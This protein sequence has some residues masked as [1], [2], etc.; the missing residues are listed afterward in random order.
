MGEATLQKSVDTK[1]HLSFYGGHYGTN[2]YLI[3]VSNFTEH[4]IMWDVFNQNTIDWVSLL[5]TLIYEVLGE[6]QVLTY[7]KGS[8]GD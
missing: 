5:E 8:I 6:A 4:T 7:F 3:E 1:K 2:H